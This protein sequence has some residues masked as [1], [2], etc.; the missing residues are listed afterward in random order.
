MSD[1]V[2]NS[3]GRRYCIQICRGTGDPEIIEEY[4]FRIAASME[5]CM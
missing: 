5:S 4:N 3:N 2:I 1:D